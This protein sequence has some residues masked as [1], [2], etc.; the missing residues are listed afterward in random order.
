VG[1]TVILST[2]NRAEILRETLE[3]MTVVDREGLDAEWVVVNNNSS[4]H[5]DS[6][7]RSFVE[8]LPIRHL[9]EA[10]PGKNI[11]INTAINHAN[12]GEV[13]VFTDDDVVPERD[14]L[15]IIHAACERHTEFNVFGG[16][17]EVLW[18]GVTPPTW[19]GR[20][21]VDSVVFS[22]HRPL[23]CEGSYP[24]EKLPF[25]PNFWLRRQLLD[26]GFRY[27][28][29][30]GPRP[31]NRIMGSESS[32]LK[33]LR[34]AG[35]RAWY[36]PNAIVGHRIDP[37]YLDRRLALRRGFRLGRSQPHLSG[38]PRQALFMRSEVTWACLQV[39]GLAKYGMKLARWSIGRQGPARFERQLHALM[40]VGAKYECLRL[41]RQSHGVRQDSE[42]RSP[43]I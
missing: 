7:I 3:A 5:T 9:S 39:L 14:W 21:L 26:K 27:N 16:A 12:L 32:F 19:T 13:V 33:Q 6:V 35:H 25:G 8:R 38:L 15:K 11:A 31:T 18:D 10:R 20:Q 29:A 36:V 40:G 34:D 1:I 4:D 30:V 41:W 42:R 23:L 2:Y 22:R 37:Q 28:E 17:V 24:D 43:A